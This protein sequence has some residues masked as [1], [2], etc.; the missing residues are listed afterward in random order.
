MTPCPRHCTTRALRAMM[1]VQLA[2]SCNKVHHSVLDLLH[3]THN[4]VR[5]AA[6]SGLLTPSSS[7]FQQAKYCSNLP[8][9]I[10]RLAKYIRSGI[11][12][13]RYNYLFASLFTDIVLGMTCHS[14]KRSM[15]N[16]ILSMKQ[17]SGWTNPATSTSMVNEPINRLY[18]NQ[19]FT[20]W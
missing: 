4:Q 11:F 7:S 18:G 2:P 9:R 5:F 8:G 16:Q 14:I 15:P 12:Y 13:E 19:L 17:A 3:S 20:A 6:C 1:L 10:A